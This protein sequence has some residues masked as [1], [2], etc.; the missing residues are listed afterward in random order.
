LLHSVFLPG[1]RYFLLNLD[2]CR[3]YD[4]QLLIDT[5]TGSYERLPRETRVYITLN[6]I[7][8]RYFRMTPEGMK[9]R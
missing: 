1:D 2:N 3:N 8:N 5:Q 4:G 9:Y 6:T 7:T